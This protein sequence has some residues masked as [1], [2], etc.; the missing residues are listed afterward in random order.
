[1]EVRDQIRDMRDQISALLQ[2]M[3]ELA[4]NSAAAAKDANFALQT[5]IYDATDAQRTVSNLVKSAA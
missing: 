4:A 3:Q 2:Q 1:M 5:L